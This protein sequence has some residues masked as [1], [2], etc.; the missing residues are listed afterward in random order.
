MSGWAQREAERQE[1]EQREIDDLRA[2]LETC[3]AQNKSL[4]ARVATLEEII[5]GRTTPPTDAEIDA[6]AAVGGWRQVRYAYRTEVVDAA[7]AR[8]AVE[9]DEPRVLRWWSVD[10]EHRP[11]AW[12]TVGVPHG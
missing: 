5:E 6:H 4:A 11:C 9:P 8:V 10:G 3:E 12:P 7:A 2:A 1:D